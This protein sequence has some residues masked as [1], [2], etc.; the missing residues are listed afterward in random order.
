MATMQTALFS[1]FRGMDLEGASDVML[2]A[3]QMALSCG[4][5][6]QLGADMAWDIFILT[7]VILLGIAMF[8]HPKLGP[9][10]GVSGIVIGFAGIALNWYAFPTPPDA[11]GLID[12]GPLVG[13]WFLIVAL[14]VLFSLK[15]LGAS[16][17]TGSD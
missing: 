16:N 4:N 9:V 3:R 6:L 11:F 17:K 15:W 10:F 8:R 1:T 7:S 13:I 14:K 2:T 5:A 12:V